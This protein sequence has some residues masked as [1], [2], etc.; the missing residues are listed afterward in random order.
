MRWCDQRLSPVGVKPAVQSRFAR[1]DVLRCGGFTVIELLVVIGIIGVLLAILLPTLAKVRDRANSAACLSNL[2]Q[3]G[4]ALS[5][6][7]DDHHG[8]LVPGDYLGLIDGFPQPGAGNWADILV[9]GQY[10]SAPT[11]AYNA[12]SDADFE[13]GIAKRDTVLRCPSGQD[14][15]AADGYPTSATDSRGSFYFSRG[16]DASQ[17]AV[18]TWYAIN[19]IPRLP[20][21]SLTDQQ[22][23]PLPFSFLPDYGSGSANWTINKLSRLTA[24]VPLVFDGVWCF[25]GSPSIVNAC[26]N[27]RHGSERYT[28]LLF[29]DLHCETQLS[30]T[31]PNNDWYLH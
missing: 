21:A 19:C 7:A 23:Q 4:L 10:V 25:S 14:Y 29:G 30:S 22:L 13:E 20:D 26:I 2:R 18:L 27:A 9:D 1:T 15:N 5:A 17:S 12:A 8:C 24:T 3:I 6:Y 16:S 11:G 31:L 28:N